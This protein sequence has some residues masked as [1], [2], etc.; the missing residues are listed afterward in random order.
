MSEQNNFQLTGDEARLL[1]V[2]L[3][4]SMANAPSAAVLSLYRRLETI[5]T[6]QPPTQRDEDDE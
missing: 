2:A 6:V 5:S 3:A 4:T 1:M